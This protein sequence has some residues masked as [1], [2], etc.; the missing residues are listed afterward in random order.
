MGNHLTNAPTK[1]PHTSIPV[2]RCINSLESLLG[3]ISSLTESSLK[4][5][6]GDFQEARHQ[7]EIFWISMWVKACLCSVAV[8]SLVVHPGMDWEIWHSFKMPSIQITSRNLYW[9]RAQCLA[10]CL[11]YKLLHSTLLFIKYF[12]FLLSEQFYTKEKT[13]T[14]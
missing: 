5:K 1:P 12:L 13:D 6:D 11:M 10:S 14:R 7:A 2:H 3:E 8:P 4:L 9:R